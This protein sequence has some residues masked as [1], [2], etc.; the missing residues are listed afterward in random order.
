[1][2]FI[3]YHD[4]FVTNV[5]T[6]G[7]RY[8]QHLVQLLLTISRVVN[9]FLSAVFSAKIGEH[10]WNLETKISSQTHYWAEISAKSHLDSVPICYHFCERTGEIRVDRV[11]SL[12][13]EILSSFCTLSHNSADREHRASSRNSDKSGA[14]LRW[15]KLAA[16]VNVLA[17]N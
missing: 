3:A 17:S 5:E 14:E 8:T 4:S 1:M 7:I 12:K 9:G 10:L 15:D 2:Q 13:L 11:L 16:K 6:I